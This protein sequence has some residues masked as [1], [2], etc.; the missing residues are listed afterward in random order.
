MIVINMKNYC[1]PQIAE[2]FAHYLKWTQRLTCHRAEREL[3]GSTA[4]NKSFLSKRLLKVNASREE[5]EGERIEEH[6]EF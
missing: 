5:G 4:E 6:K 2:M 3:M 1:A